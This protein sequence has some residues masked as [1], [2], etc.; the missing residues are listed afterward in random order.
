ML[1]LLALMT[2]CLLNASD[3]DVS[4]DATSEMPAS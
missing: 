2:V 3:A 4:V 1:V